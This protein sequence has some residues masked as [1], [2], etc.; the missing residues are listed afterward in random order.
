MVAGIELRHARLEDAGPMAAL[1]GQLGYPATAAEVTERIG[2]LLRTPEAHAVF[3]VADPAGLIGW[4]HLMRVDRVES[5]PHAEI[6]ALVVGETHRGHGIGAQLVHAAITWAQDRGLASLT[7][8]SRIERDGAHR[9]YQR[10]GFALEKTQ[11]VMT[12]AV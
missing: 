3:V 2:T 8:R 11:H 12:R 7:V 10:M 4:L 9:F 6:A 5:P 1:S